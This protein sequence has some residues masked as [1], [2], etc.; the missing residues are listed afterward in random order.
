MSGNVILGHNDPSRIFF[1]NCDFSCYS[2]DCFVSAG[3]PDLEE[4]WAV[5]LRLISLKGISL[6]EKSL[7]Q[8]GGSQENSL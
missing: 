1:L 6:F 7:F 2:M 4:I 5:V 8:I 3:K